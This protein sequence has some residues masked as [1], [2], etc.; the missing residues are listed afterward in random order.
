MEISFIDGG[1]PEHLKKT[2]DLP[3]VTDKLYHIMFYPVHLA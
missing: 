2:I 3:Q 1:N